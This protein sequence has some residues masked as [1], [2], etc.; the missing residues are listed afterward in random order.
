MAIIYQ[1]TI[2]YRLCSFS[3]HLFDNNN[4][5]D[6][7]TAAGI[8]M[9]QVYFTVIIPE[10]TGIYQSFSTFHQHRISP[11]A[12]NIFCPDHIN[13]KIRIRIINVKFSLMIPDG[14]SPYSITM[15]YLAEMIKWRLL[16]QSITNDRPVD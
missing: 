16:F 7:R 13:S 8:S 1:R 10:R 9:G 4:T 15:L 12:C 6:T 11:W 3:I 5:L 2:I 14:G